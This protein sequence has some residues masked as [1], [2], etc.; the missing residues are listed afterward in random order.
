MRLDLLDLVGDLVEHLIEI[1]EEGHCA[2]NLLVSKSMIHI[3]DL[4]GVNVLRV[5][6][7]DLLDPLRQGKVDHMILHPRFYCYEMVPEGLI[8]QLFLCLKLRFEYLGFLVDHV[9]CSG[10]KPKLKVFFVA[11][12]YDSVDIDAAL[13]DIL[14]TLGIKVILE[15]GKLHDIGPHVEPF[16][17]SLLCVKWLYQIAYRQIFT[18]IIFLILIF[19]LELGSL[20]HI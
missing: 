7:V 6:F 3:W 10:E 9:T 12:L 14:D 13:D 18:R 15:K 17:H 2:V 5:E 20:I 16:Y 11:L 1:L 8:N 19:F 4:V